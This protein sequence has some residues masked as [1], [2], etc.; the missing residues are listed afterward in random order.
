MSAMDAEVLAQLAGA[1]DVL[2]GRSAGV[3]VEDDHGHR[4]QITKAYAIGARTD[5]P[6]LV[7]RL[8]RLGGD[9]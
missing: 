6:G 4:Y 9:R 8:M 1:V 3:V 7:I 5:D 2:K